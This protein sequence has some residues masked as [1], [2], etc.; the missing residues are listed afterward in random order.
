MMAN[1]FSIF[2]PAATFHFPLNWGASLLGL[3]L[4]PWSYWVQPNR[5]SKM[6]LMVTSQLHLEFK[7]LVGPTSSQ[8][9]TLIFIS[10]FALILFN[11]LLG[12][13][14]Y[15]FTSSSHLV[16]TLSLAMPLWVSFMIYGWFNHTRH[17]LAHLVPLG[18]P[19]ILMPFM[20]LIETIS[21]VIRPG[22]LAVRLAANMIAGHLLLVLLGNQG[23]SMSSFL[24]SILLVTQILL[25]T[26]ESAVAIIQSYVFAVLATLYSSEVV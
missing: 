2:D 26:L 8:G 11:N 13:L 7:T 16:M 9:H 14:P 19:G 25:L 23:P 18:T 22:T 4:I 12:L 17:M 15:V 5:Y 10:L 3:F 24:L 1:L 20:V 21:N 6:F